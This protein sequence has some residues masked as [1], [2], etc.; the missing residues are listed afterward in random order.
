[1]PKNADED[2]LQRVIGVLATQ[3]FYDVLRPLE[4]VIHARKP[5]A[6]TTR[7]AVSFIRAAPGG[8]SQVLAAL[9]HLERS[10]EPDD[11]PY[12]YQHRDRTVGALGLRSS[13]QLRTKSAVSELVN[14][15]VDLDDP[16]EAA[17][18][19]LERV[20]GRIADLLD[21][22]GDLERARTMPDR[23]RTAAFVQLILS[24]TNED[25]VSAVNATGRDGMVLQLDGSLAESGPDVDGRPWMLTPYGVVQL[26]DDWPTVDG[27]VPRW[28][29]AARPDPRARLGL[30]L[31]SRKHPGFSTHVA[32]Y[33]P[34]PR[35]AAALMVMDRGP[36]KALRHWTSDADLWTL[37]SDLGLALPNIG[38]IE[39]SEL[40]ELLLRL[41]GFEYTT[42]P[43]GWYSLAASL[44]GSNWEGAWSPLRLCRTVENEYALT[45]SCYLWLLQDD[46]TRENTTLRDLQGV[47]GTDAMR[48][49]KGKRRE[50]TIRRMTFGEKIALMD[51]VSRSR[52]L[53]DR[54]DGRMDLTR[55]ASLTGPGIRKVRDIRNEIAHQDDVPV[56]I[57]RDAVLAWF[58]EVGLGHSDVGCP[59]PLRVRP[60]RSHLDEYLC[61]NSWCED[62]LGN[63]IRI[64]NHD[65]IGV[66]LT[67]GDPRQLLDPPFFVRL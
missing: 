51:D 43:S 38:A 52:L 11:L 4:G 56:A 2:E 15:L 6:R 53:S 16:E 65:L 57:V 64:G 7:D 60:T 35:S 66:H 13:R 58:D 62:E 8:S 47:L 44:R 31:A 67:L 39:R 1:M 20:A 26:P 17:P 12:V 19:K 10:A 24:G 5:T 41:L 9:N 22:I 37:L 61:E 63:E 21:G 36:I 46:D 55:I 3:H 48:L 42:R 33:H 23:L 25:I 28:L 30:L 45:L 14:F 29:N 34:D 40:E 18:R 54:L 32:S 59:L 50:R 27:S 49:L